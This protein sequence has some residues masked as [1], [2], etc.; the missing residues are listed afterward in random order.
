[1]NDVGEKFKY[2]YWKLSLF[3]KFNIKSTQV[4]FADAKNLFLIKF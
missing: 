3:D 2:Y 1:M 4:L